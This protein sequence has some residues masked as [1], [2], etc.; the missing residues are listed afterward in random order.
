MTDRAV[1]YCRVSTDAQERDGTSLDHQQEQCE[2]YC[3][4]RGYSVV[5]TYRESYSGGSID[6]PELSRL[7]ALLKERRASVVVAYAVDRLSRSQNHIGIL[8]D[9]IATA[10]ARLELV[11]E[12]FEDTAVGRFILAARAF[13]AEV[14]REK[15]A[16]RTKTGK[17]NRAAEGKYVYSRPPYGYTR[18]GK[19]EISID[20][21]RAAVVR[22]IFSRFLE[23]A[24]YRGIAVTLNDLGVPSSRGKP[25]E[26]QVIKKMLQNE[27]YV[28]TLLYSGVRVEHAIPAIETQERFDRAQAQMTARPERGGGRG[29]KSDHL[30]TSL[31][32]CE[33]GARMH[34][35]THR[36]GTVPRV[37]TCSRYSKGGGCTPTAHDAE[38]V[39]DAVVAWLGDL[40]ADYPR[41]ERLRT[42]A[43]D[44][45]RADL[46]TVE[47]ALAENE[48]ERQNAIR[49]IRRGDPFAQEAAQAVVEDRTR[50][51]DQKAQVE[52][53]IRQAE[54]D[55]ED[56]ARLPE[57]VKKLLDPSL[58]IEA[59]KRILQEA[60]KH[61]RVIVSFEGAVSIE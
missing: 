11:S 37:Y 49:A 12:T 43:I 22:D 25:W 55:R 35:R 38:A 18:T 51:L 14:E 50:L 31:V 59:R 41:I 27:A 61:S 16:T 30:L 3:R 32:Y 8:F 13:V 19:G 60:L 36:K 39:E 48:K 47:A 29:A 9:E 2:R 5:E 26:R 28:G 57:Q 6:R 58:T 17:R 24:S 45:I 44:R 20:E 7:R 4:E 23:G 52:E 46:A 54:R 42:S 1:I 40:I 21:P 56:D 15:I 10:K 33:C 34:G 53:R